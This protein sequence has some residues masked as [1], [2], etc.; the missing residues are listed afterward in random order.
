MVIAIQ[1]INVVAL[2]IMGALMG[3]MVVVGLRSE[4]PREPQGPPAIEEPASPAEPMVSASTE[5]ALASAES[6]DA[7]FAGRPR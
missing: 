5:P 3:T 7:W 2:T 1:G 4:P 6:L